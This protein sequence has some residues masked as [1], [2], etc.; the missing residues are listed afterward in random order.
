MAKNN[1]KNNGYFIF[2]INYFV[3]DMTNG[4]QFG[5]CFNH[6]LLNRVENTASNC[7]MIT[8]LMSVSKILRP[9]L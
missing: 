3:I 5:N 1:S 6:D 4:T 2:L 7:S 8:V 9:R